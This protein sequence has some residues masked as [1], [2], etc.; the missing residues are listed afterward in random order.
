MKKNQ[1]PYGGVSIRVGYFVMLCNFHRCY[2]LCPAVMDIKM[3]S[4]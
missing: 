1:N 3:P 2:F 4:H